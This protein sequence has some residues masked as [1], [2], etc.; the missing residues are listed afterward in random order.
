MAMYDNVLSKNTIIIFILF[1]RTNHADL[2]ESA[3][4]WTPN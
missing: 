4:I 2:Q 1:T 3:D